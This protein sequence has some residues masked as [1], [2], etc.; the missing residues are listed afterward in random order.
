ML[1]IE[2]KTISDKDQK[3]NTVGAYWEE[4]DKLMITISDMKN[5]KNEV[6]IA[7]HELVESSLCKSRGIKLEE[8]PKFDK[9]FEK[10]RKYGIL[11][12]PG[13]EPGAPY[14][15]EHQFAIKMENL[16]AQELG[17]NWDEHNK[18]IT[19]LDNLAQ[20]R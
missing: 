6:L 17:I 4:E 11:D 19:E 13:N 20:E 9:Q 18:L 10:K 14:H 12:E 5:W 1:N 3:Y 16:F 2:I 8:I 7:L 15:R